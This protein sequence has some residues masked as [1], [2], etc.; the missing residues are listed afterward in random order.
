MESVLGANS[1]SSL[2]ND[3]QYQDFVMKDKVNYV[4]EKLLSLKLIIKNGFHVN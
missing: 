1:S 2:S 4:H 3:K